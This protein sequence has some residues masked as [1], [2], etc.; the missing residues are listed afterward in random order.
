MKIFMINKKFV[1]TVE[2][3]AMCETSVWEENLKFITPR[4]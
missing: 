3:H 2:L 4:S 1:M